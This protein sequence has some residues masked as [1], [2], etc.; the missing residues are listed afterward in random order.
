MEN[1]F[2]SIDRSITEWGWYQNPNTARV[3]IHC[4]LKANW[5]DGEFEGHTILRGSFVTSLHKLS[6]ETGLSIQQTRT[7]LNHLKST[8]EL[9]IKSTNKF[10]II[11][12][13][14]YDVYQNTGRRSTSRTTNDLTINQQT[15]NKQLTTIEQSNNITSI[16]RESI[17]R[18]P[19]RKRVVF[20]PPSVDDVKGYCQENGYK[21]DANRFVDFYESKGWMVGKNKMKDWKAAV[22]TWARS[23]K[24]EP[25]KDGFSNFKERED[26]D[27]DAVELALLQ[28]R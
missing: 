27:W 7:A 19:E 8:N 14:K 16:K 13:E 4:L 10:T 12:V 24:K 28:R 3:F 23:E 18:E 5:K 25:K 22:R 26:T 2:I 1:G 9:T 15:T 6:Q 17:E 21:V 20:A 11:T